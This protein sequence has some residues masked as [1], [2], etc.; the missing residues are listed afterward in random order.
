MIKFLTKG[1]LRDRSRSLFPVFVVTLTV[2][3]IVFFQGFMTGVTS[4]FF[5]DTAVVSSG[6]MKIMTRAYDEENQLLPVAPSHTHNVGWF[7]VYNHN[8]SKQS[9][10]L[11][12]I[13]S[14]WMSQD[15]GLLRRHKRLLGQSM[16]SIED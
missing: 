5:R 11:V 16:Q 15:C 14:R 12:L 10:L 8:N 1:I 2:A 4:G 7:R 6:H 3:M 9:L 13:D